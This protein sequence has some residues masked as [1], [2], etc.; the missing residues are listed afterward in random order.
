MISTLP[1]ETYSTNSVIMK[2][3]PV[4]VMTPT[5]SPALAVATPMPIMLRAPSTSPRQ[6]SPTPRQAAPASAP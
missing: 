3:M 5:I 2:P 4:S 1:P 6:R